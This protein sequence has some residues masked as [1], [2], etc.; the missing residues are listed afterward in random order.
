MKKMFIVVLALVAVCCFSACGANRQ[1]QPTATPAPTAPAVEPTAEPAVTPAPTPNVVETDAPETETPSVLNEDD[2]AA[3][4]EAMGLDKDST[5]VKFVMNS[6]QA[7]NAG[8]ILNAE[9]EETDT[10]R[11]LHVSTENGLDLRIYLSP[12]NSVEGILDDISKQ[13]LVWSTK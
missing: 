3:I 7:V 13:W 2:V 5:K 4:A 11:M 12:G 10:D 9:M 8:H 1:E 6:L